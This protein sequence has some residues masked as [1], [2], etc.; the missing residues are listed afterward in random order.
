MGSERVKGTLQRLIGSGIAHPRRS[1]PSCVIFRNFSVKV[2]ARILRRILV[3][4]YIYILEKWFPFVRERAHS[5]IDVKITN[6]NRFN[7]NANAFQ[8]LL[9]SNQKKLIF[10]SVQE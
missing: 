6:T 10:F 7:Q 5:L 1:S 4:L 3:T 2:V 8:H 9:V